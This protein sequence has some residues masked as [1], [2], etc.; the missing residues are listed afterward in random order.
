MSGLLGPLCEVGARNR[1]FSGWLGPNSAP[2]AGRIT[3]TTCCKGRKC[4]EKDHFGR[5][6]GA[7]KCS[8]IIWL[9]A[10]AHV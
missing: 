5:G 2:L 6:D 3:K 9:C 10:A 8:G 1:V 7:E 4:K